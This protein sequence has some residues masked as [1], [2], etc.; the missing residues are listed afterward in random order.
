L[1]PAQLPDLAVESNCAR[2]CVRGS[3]GNGICCELP[4]VE[5]PVVVGELLDFDDELPQPA[6]ST[7]VTAS[8]AAVL[9]VRDIFL[10]QR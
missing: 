3:F 7:A 5:V 4:L 2:Y 10:P 9:V 8:A 6:A 1:K